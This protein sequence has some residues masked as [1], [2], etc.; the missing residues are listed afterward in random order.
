MENGI[1]NICKSKGTTSAGV[2]RVL[3]DKLGADK[4]G[5]CG[6]LDPLARGVLLVCFGRATKLFT[7]LN[8][9]RKTYVVTAVL[10][11]ETDSGDMDGRVKDYRENTEVLPVKLIEDALR[12]F[13]GEIEQEPPVYSAIKHNGKRLY[14]YAREGVPVR[15]KSRKVT[16]YE[17]NLRKYIHPYM[18]LNVVCSS[19]TYVRSLVADIGRKLGTFASVVELSRTSIGGF[20]IEEGIDSESI[21]EMPNE[22]IRERMIIPDDYETG[23]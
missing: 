19:G 18:Q 11:F 2:V 1:L 3:K 10:G 22:K 12:A 7:R 20:G 13:T 8:E 6:T 14:S 5:H 16:I 9:Q 23:H 4:V 15:P 21:I 17:L